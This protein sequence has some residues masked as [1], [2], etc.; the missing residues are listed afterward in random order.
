MIL[1]GKNL[2][3]EALMVHLD[4]EFFLVMCIKFIWGKD[5]GLL[6]MIWVKEKGLLQKTMALK[7]N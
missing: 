5:K 4:M 3:M 2:D 7:L 1:D 6:Q